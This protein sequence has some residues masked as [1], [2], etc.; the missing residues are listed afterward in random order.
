MALV[1]AVFE[2]TV[3]VDIVY[4]VF[5]AICTLPTGT[6]DSVSVLIASV[7]PRK[8]LSIFSCTSGKVVM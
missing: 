8:S 2:I 1:F 5:L 6:E 4:S 3:F 7:L